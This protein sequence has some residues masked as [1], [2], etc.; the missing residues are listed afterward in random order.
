MVSGNETSAYNGQYLQ[1]TGSDSN[2]S[3]VSDVYSATNWT[4]VPSTGYIYSDSEGYNDVL[5][6]YN[7]YCVDCVD[8]LF[9]YQNP[10]DNGF[11]PVSYK[12]AKQSSTGYQILTGNTTIGY[13][14]QVVYDG[15]IAMTTAEYDRTDDYGPIVLRFIEWYESVEL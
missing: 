14:S 12:T 2:P 11:L 3:L 13:D 10:T 5:C 8:Y 7:Q 6:V 1:D 4:L 15:S 9:T